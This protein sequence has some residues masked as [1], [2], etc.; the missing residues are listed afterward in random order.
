MSYLGY[1]NCRICGEQLGTR[2]FFGYGFVWPEKAEH[3]VINH[4]VW[5]KECDEMLI[6]VRKTRR[7]VP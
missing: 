7:R 6:A 3:Y 1:A 4:H 2:D 5:T